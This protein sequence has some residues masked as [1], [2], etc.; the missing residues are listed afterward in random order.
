MNYSLR[1]EITIF[2]F[3]SSEALKNF[4]PSVIWNDFSSQHG[5]LEASAINLTSNG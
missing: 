1:D 2:Y 5:L 4:L 3:L